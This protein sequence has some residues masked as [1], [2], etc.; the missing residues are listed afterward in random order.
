[1][2]KHN[3]I[4]VVW[5]ISAVH[6]N[7]KTLISGVLLE[8]APF[9]Y[10][11][12]IRS[13]KN[14]LNVIKSYFIS[15]Y[16]NKKISITTNNITINTNTD[17]YGSFSIVVDFLH[18]GELKINIAENVSPL[19]ILQT[20]PI[21]FKN[22]KSP[23]NV[24]SDIDDTIIVSYTASFFKR[25]GTLALTTPNK[26]ETI[27]FTQKLFKEFKKQNVRVFYVSKSESNLFG[28]LTSFI[29]YNK[30]PK[31]QLILTPYLKFSQLLN[32]KKKQNFKFNNI[33]FIIENSITN[34]FVLVGDDSQQDME[35]YLNITREFPKRILKIYIRQTKNKVLLYQKQMWGK[36][37][38]TGI[39]VKYFKA[40]SAIDVV[41]E[42]EQLKNNTL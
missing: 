40:D 21:I 16:Q 23:F 6:L 29:K 4:P 7:R 8:T 14:L 24:I 33:R 17:S 32:P 18:I 36:L 22:T 31:G 5:Q 42:M 12:Q 34:G 25:I 30:L 3:N 39:P 11:K 41:K 27:S 15:T 38:L 2:G 37:K 35:I 19:R 28:M 9:A 26:R 13:L 20:Y 1:M 10:D